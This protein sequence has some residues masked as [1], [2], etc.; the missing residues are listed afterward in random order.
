[1]QNSTGPAIRKDELTDSSFE[2]LGQKWHRFCSP[3]GTIWHQTIFWKDGSRSFFGAHPWGKI[4]KYELVFLGTEMKNQR[5]VRI[6]RQSDNHEYSIL[7]KG[8][9]IYG[10]RL[11]QCGCQ[12]VAYGVSAHFCL[13]KTHQFSCGNFCFWFYGVRR[14]LAAGV[15]DNMPI[16]FVTGGV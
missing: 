2:L 16:V 9:A 3:T 11:P 13:V 14:W 12:K 7:K 5:R 4:W 8:M 1:M 10:A 15:F 6:T